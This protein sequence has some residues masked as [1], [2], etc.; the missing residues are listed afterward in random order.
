[1]GSIDLPPFLR[2]KMK[3]KIQQPKTDAVPP[4]LK[5]KED[6]VDLESGAPIIFPSL[7]PSELSSEVIQNNIF[8][9]G[10]KLKK[11]EPIPA[12]IP[13]QQQNVKSAL[14]KVHYGSMS[15]RELSELANNPNTS[16]LAKAI[17]KEQNPE[18]EDD[19][20]LSGE[21]IESAAKKIKQKNRINYF[22]DEA[23]I[24]SSSKNEVANSLVELAKPTTRNAGQVNEYI[25]ELRGD[26]ASVDLSDRNKVAE[27][28]SKLRKLEMVEQR[29][30]LT[31]KDRV[32]AL[33]ES[34]TLIAKLNSILD[35]DVSKN[36]TSDTINQLNDQI[37]KAVVS[38]VMESER[39]EGVD[40][41]GQDSKKIEQ[42][43]LGLSRIELSDP[44]LFKNVISTISGKGK[45]ADSD[46][47][48]ISNVGQQIY[49]RTVF[50]NAAHDP[51]LIDAETD[52]DFTTLGEKKADAASKI[53]EWLKAN[54]YKNMNA[55][56]EKLIRQA[57]AATG[58]TNP[59]IVNS[60]VLEEGLP[61]YD[62][63]PKS[64]WM[65][66]IYRG[67]SGVVEG[68]NSTLN[69]WNES[70]AQTY[71]RSKELSPSEG[72][73]SQKV[74][75]K[76]GQYSDLLPSES[77]R[78][79]T[80]MLRGL[81]QFIPQILLTK[82]IGAGVTAGTG[83]AVPLSAIQGRNLADFAGTG[84]STYV[85]TY[86]DAYAN[87][88]Q[89]T[90]DAEESA[91]M[92]SIDATASA[93]FE[94]LLPDVKI[95]DRAFRG[96]KGALSNDLLQLVKKGGDPAQ[97]AAKARP[98]VQK[99][100]T[101][102][103]GTL[104]QENL[105][106]LGTQYV[107]FVTESIFDPMSA[108]DRDLSKELWDTFKS[109][110]TAMA[111]PAVLGGGLQ[112][113]P[114]DFTRSTLH[115]ASLNFDSY[116]ESLEKSLDKGEINQDQYNTA[117]SLL[118]T[119]KQ[120][121][122]NAPKTN[123]NNAPLDQKQ[124]LDYAYEDTKIKVYKEKAE[125]TEGVAKEMWDAKIKQA[126]DIQRAIL[127]PQ[128]SVQQ[129]TTVTTP[130]G[131]EQ[132]TVAL[133]PEENAAVEALKFKPFPDGSMS[134]SASVLKDDNA[135]PEQK[136]EALKFFSDQLNA[137]D[138]EAVTGEL[139]GRDAELI[140][141]LN[142]EKPQQD[143]ALT[144]VAKFPV[145][146]DDFAKKYFTK[147]EQAQ[148][149]SLVN[150]G[151]EQEA[152]KM[153]SDKKS[154]ITTA[155]TS[156]PT[157]EK[158][159]ESFVSPILTRMNNA[160]YINEKELDEAADELYTRLED[161]QTDDSFTPEQRKNAE[162]LIEPLIEK[163]EGYEFRTTTQNRQVTE[164]TATQVAKPARERKTKPPLEASTGSN[165]TI[166]TPDGKTVK[167]TL[168]IRNGNYVLD[169]PGGTQRVIGEKAITDR[170]LSL[171]DIEQQ[172]LA[173]DYDESGNF[174]LTV[175][176]RNGNLITITDPEKALDAA[177][178]MRAQS[179][180]EVSQEEFDT[181]YNTVVKEVPEEVLVKQPEKIDKKEVK[182][183]TKDTKVSE[184]TEEKKPTPKK[185]SEPVK[186]AKTRESKS[187]RQQ[188]VQSIADELRDLLNGNVSK[189]ISDV[190]ADTEI[191][192]E[193]LGLEFLKDN[194]YEY[195]L[196]YVLG[197][198]KS[199]NT[200]YANLIE[201]IKTIPGA[202]DVNVR[203]QTSEDVKDGGFAGAYISRANNRHLPIEDSRILIVNPDTKNQLYTIV[204]EVMHWV[205]LDSGA[206]DLAS[207]EL[208]K[209][210]RDIY[211]VIRKKY[212]GAQYGNMVTYGLY[213]YDEFLAEL[214]INP[215]FRQEVS[216]VMVANEKEFKDALGS[217]SSKSLVEMLVDLVKDALSKLFGDG[218]YAESI[219]FNKPL[220]D[221]AIDLAAKILIEGNVNLN[222]RG[223][224]INRNGIKYSTLSQGTN[225]SRLP[226]N[227]N[228]SSNE[229]I[230]K[231]IK[232]KL[233]QGEATDVIREALKTLDIPD[234]DINALLPKANIQFDDKS[235]LNRIVDSEEVSEDTKDL[236]RSE[237]LK[238]EI[239]SQQLARGLARGIINEFG[240]DEA[241]LMA[242]G[243]RFHGDVNSFIFAES[244]D[245]IFSIEQAEQD[246][247]LK[248]EA[249]EKYAD[250]SLRYQDAA[251]SGGRFISAIRDYYKK[252]PA[253]LV[254]KAEREFKRRQDEYFKGRN[255]TTRE[256]LQ[257]LLDTVEG[258]EMLQEE[259]AKSQK[260]GKKKAS[261]KIFTDE[262]SS[263]IKNF[264]KGL[265]I[266]TK[267]NTGSYL[268]PPQIY[269]AA[270]DI[271]EQAVLAGVSIGKA[272]DQAI[273][274]IGEKYNGTWD[275]KQFKADIRQGFKKQNVQRVLTQE[276]K[277]NLLKKWARKLTGLS[278]DQ[279]ASL[280]NKSFLDL[281]EY[282]AL[283][284][285]RFKDLYAEAAGL[286]Q[287]TPDLAS[288]LME[289]A[290]AINKPDQI[291]QEILKTG[292]A[293][294][295]DDYKKAVRDSEK[296]STEL[297]QLIGRQKW[298]FNTFLTVMR[299]NTL[300]TVS[301]LG[302][303]A[304]NV[305]TMPF[306]FATN[307][308]ATGL[309]Y[310]LAG[311][312]K[313]ADKLFG[314]SLYKNPP[315]HNVF[316]IQGGYARGAWMGT[317]DAIRQFFTGLTNRDYFQREIKQNI[318]PLTSAKKFIRAMSGKE[319]ATLNEKINAF[320]EGFPTMGMS[321]EVVARA[322]NVGDKGFR[323]GAE[324]AMAN[325]LADRKGLKGDAREVFILFPDEDSEQI[326]KD[327]GEKAV[328][329]QKHVVSQLM[330]NVGNTI[331]GFLKDK[332]TVPKTLYGVARTIG[333][334]TQP[335]LNTPL[336][337][338]NEFIHY[339]FPPLPLVRAGIAMKDG[340]AEKAT[341]HL[342]QAVV[343]LSFMYVATQL[344]ANGIII[345]AGSDD[346]EKKEREGIAAYQRRGQMNVSGLKRLL[347]GSYNGVEDGDV[348][349]D[350]RYLG[351]GGMMLLSKA[352][353]YRD[354]TQEQ[355]KQ[356]TMLQDIVMQFPSAVKGGLTQGVFGGT[357]SLMN[358]VSMGGGYVDNWLIGMGNVVFNAFEPSW[359]RS[360]SNSTTTNDYLRDTKGMNLPERAL[361]ELKN[362]AFAGGDLPAKINIWGDKVES[363]PQGKNA[364]LYNFFGLSKT[365]SF[366]NDKFGYILYDYYNQTKDRNLF[367]PALRREVQGT[368]LTGE[369]YEQFSILVG[370]HR[371]QLV[372]PYLESGE[373]AEDK[374]QGVETVTKRLGK[375][376][377]AARKLAVTEFLN[378]YPD[379]Q[380]NKTQLEN[381]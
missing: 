304:A 324:M 127:M 81:G 193:D 286:P 11:K 69:T 130:E 274:Y 225:V 335:F 359:L 88:L 51:N 98:F 333:Y 106:E 92:A 283:S 150:D 318:K 10:N 307:L 354:N 226:Q 137:P 364:F 16:E 124:Q 121:I 250:I 212:D 376:Y 353:Q 368:K 159:T 299:L 204:H 91:F 302:N 82:S 113:L 341:H 60:L 344:V 151:N 65:D 222:Q 361:N 227:E 347:A 90:G 116:K 273:D 38:K 111:I 143:A 270:I 240:I 157:K 43:K 110:T 194:K 129:T 300:G 330:D 126:E 53:G 210:L 54:G 358:A 24:E 279:R 315:A 267:S 220:I 197:K 209:P 305:T 21:S 68:M 277:D 142:Y 366:D 345:S 298:W 14:A 319:K 135:T 64:G 357:S 260:D 184:Q 181:V 360:M 158:R 45:I 41:T 170:D 321:A 79:S 167:G 55:F 95:A 337:V 169:V 217:N 309:D 255:K 115:T 284:Y 214:L 138:T 367:P 179:I 261:K 117:I 269:N 84:I 67:A 94:Q 163:I 187:K 356:Q 155:K 199:Q 154:E 235:I 352:D 93:A 183:E 236:I 308:T 75:N 114:K 196:H 198:I 346:E 76:E 102:A 294:K 192:L 355:I 26:L 290:G 176:D 320:I 348:W 1:M 293:K 152:A 17:V 2:D 156:K 251:E 22:N 77:D 175:K 112:S 128:P 105:E 292:D 31:E 20:L 296:A 254:K 85:Q 172:P 289:L 72:I 136:R 219:D 373:F 257:E 206:F 381:E 343:G 242:E 59:E 205:T 297:N 259:I 268:L 311:A 139:L 323:F 168:N 238:Y 145:R 278:E 244:L 377:G 218:K 329:Q 203:L 374:A 34:Q 295:I 317:K 231:F 123:I 19:L 375:I 83:T 243:G 336:N 380:A 256:A 291:K 265:K 234:S 362:R 141:N 201:F 180:G 140:Y 215:A 100:L 15:S 349:I 326:I 149:N 276:E 7:S 63:I 266:D 229:I 133:T 27:A 3:E 153:V 195:S 70:P 87:H 331:S 119:N 171:P 62:A 372:A 282:G 37:E 211:D 185:T 8:D 262:T 246:P 239:R 363:V 338:F 144:E 39:G 306:R 42:F 224:V 350:L 56:P 316:A 103:A 332:G 230:R 32:S 182:N 89:K 271:V 207:D 86:G 285:D 162:A 109:T 202:N 237:G 314:T 48:M 258:Q 190:D 120:S 52:F 322:L 25:N 18:V 46:F 125:N 80:E 313:T 228:T 216:G 58:V 161:I 71:L 303:I 248:E 6:G 232:D 35:N 13:R 312:Q 104:A 247:E 369:Q 4:F 241:V 5:K 78:L 29:N 96:L 339:A 253:G 108:K 73:G 280:L 263:K 61:G 134:M 47:N 275:V 66:D 287:M 122:A 23:L 118:Q 200:E 131:V 281:M 33:N 165:A 178:Q 146:N 9:F 28:I 221:N 252:S 342:A 97:L 351:F 160:D 44:A 365:T 340:D 233:A 74:R 50:R 301:L 223:E 370:S 189:L 40:N 177:I 249:A 310:L 213:D 328:F 191:S 148:Y 101:N 208:K 173:G 371:K 132:T 49:N 186:Q 272:I 327:A 288:K 188:K 378:I 325:L 164:T 147:E 57:A 379:L 245:D 99:F 36:G 107:N 264:F 30:Y 334:G 166:T 12:N 174:S